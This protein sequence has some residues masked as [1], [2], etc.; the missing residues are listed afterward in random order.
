M[1]AKDQADMD[2]KT[3][4]KAEIATR[5]HPLKLGLE[6]AKHCAMILGATDRHTSPRHPRAKATARILKT[7]IRSKKLK[8]RVTFDV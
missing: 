6:I 5:E 1:A 7:F 4:A 3:D 2:R 8:L